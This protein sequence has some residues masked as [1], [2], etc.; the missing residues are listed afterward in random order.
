MASMDIRDL[1]SHTTEA[2]EG[3]VPE[4]QKWW[5]L[6]SRQRGDPAYY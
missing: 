4:Q 1:Q 2:Q 6:G 3:I 5:M